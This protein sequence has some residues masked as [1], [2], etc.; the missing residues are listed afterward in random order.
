MLFV[1]DASVAAAWALHDEHSEKAEKLLMKVCANEAICPGQ[2]W[3]EVRN[4]LVIAERRGRMK[5]ADSD[6]FLADLDT[7]PIEFHHGCDSVATMRLA[8]AHKLTVYDAAYLQIAIEMRLPLATIDHK[9][10]TA[11]KKEGV[12]VLSA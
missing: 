2:L 9:L 8:R 5:P 3:Y 7:L 11:A 6:R 10:E 1:L 12:R 4:A